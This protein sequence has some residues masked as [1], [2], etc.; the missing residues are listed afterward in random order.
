MVNPLP[1]EV[2][3]PVV[4]KV[5]TTS[6][7]TSRSFSV[8]GGVVW[9]TAP[10]RFR[11]RERADR[12]RGGRYFPSGAVAGNPGYFTPSGAAI[13]YDIDELNATVDLTPAPAWDVQY[14]HVVLGDGSKAYWN[15][16]TWINDDVGP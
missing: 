11:R 15:G 14:Y 6:S 12:R 7:P 8:A 4:S 2:L 16:T 1:P 5:P 10:S 9:V 3:E 13:P